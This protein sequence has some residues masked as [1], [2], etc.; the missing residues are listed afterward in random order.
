MIE[1]KKSPWKIRPK[2]LKDQNF[3]LLT[4][5]IVDGETWYTVQ[6]KKEVSIWL[7]SQIPGEDQLWFQ[8]IDDKWMMNYNTFDVS[9]E[10]YTMLALRWL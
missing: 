6:C 2:M 1:V 5:S 3:K 7:R 8:N 10:V 4:S 9:A